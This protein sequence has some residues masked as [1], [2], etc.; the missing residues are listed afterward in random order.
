M[1]IFKNGQ[2]HEFW[3]YTPFYL[4]PRANS[5]FLT[6]DSDSTGKNLSKSVIIG[7]VRRKKFKTVDER[8]GI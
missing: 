8:S 3:Q 7:Q 2:K 5:L 1:G 6:L 4:K